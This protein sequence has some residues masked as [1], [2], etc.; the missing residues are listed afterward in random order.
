MVTTSAGGETVLSNTEFEGGSKSV[1]VRPLPRSRPKNWQFQTI[2]HNCSWVYSNVIPVWCI[3]LLVHSR[4]H[5]WFFCTYRKC[6]CQRVPTSA[7]KYWNMLRGILRMLIWWCPCILPTNLSP[8]VSLKISF[9]R[10]TCFML[11]TRVLLWML[12]I[13]KYRILHLTENGQ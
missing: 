3:F 12:L 2:P 11:L 8:S 7:S 6:Y 5:W 10:K 13:Y 9:C 4:Y 1:S